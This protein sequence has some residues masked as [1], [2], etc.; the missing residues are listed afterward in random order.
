MVDGI[1]VSGSPANPPQGNPVPDDV[2]RQ[3]EHRAMT[4]SAPPGTPEVSY[5][6]EDYQPTPST[7]AYQPPAPS[8]AS[9]SP[10]AQPEPAP[11]PEAS[12]AEIQEPVL[13]STTPIDPNQQAFFPGRQKPLAEE[14]VLEWESLSRPF[15]KR[16]RQ[17]YS[18]GI[19]ITILICMI[20]FFAQQFLPIAVVV[21]VAFLAYVLSVVPPGVVKHSITTYGIRV[22]TQHLYY[23]EELGRYWFSE[24]YGEKILHI[25]VGRF[26]WRLTLLLGKVTQ[27][28]MDDILS[29]VLLNQKPPLTTMEK[30]SEWLQA[31]IPLDNDAQS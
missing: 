29:E 8:V 11:T 5:E 26:P 6:A 3:T 10:P 13:G 17:Y 24:K 2:L 7:Q 21:A 25:E 28:T 1:P 27:E 31:K 14:I 20:L 15:K 16:N 9:V 19:I 4:Q 18:T 22:D 30:A 12:E 23:W